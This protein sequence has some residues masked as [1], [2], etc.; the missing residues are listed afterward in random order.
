MAIKTLICSLMQ[1]TEKTLSNYEGF[2]KIVDA[3]EKAY[4][5]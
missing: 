4:V 5:A 2:L 1:I 3:D